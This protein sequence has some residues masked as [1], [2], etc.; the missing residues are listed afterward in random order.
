MDVTA[1]MQAECTAQQL[2]A[3]IDDLGTYPQ[4]NGLVHSAVPEAV[5]EGQLPAW[6]VELRARMGPMARSK[7]LRMVRTARD[8]GGHR[9]RFERDEE[10]GR[11]HSP[12]ILD[13]WIEER[14]G[15]STLTMQLHYG[16]ALWTGGIMER[17]LA[18]QIESGRERLMELV[19]PTR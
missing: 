10:D 1:T 4:W 7:K 3:L 19:A 15:H 14:N 17:V 2:F 9:V 13:A 16:G 12:W 18:D 5:A 6:D 8:P 11:R